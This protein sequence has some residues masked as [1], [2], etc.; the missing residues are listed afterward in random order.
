MRCFVPMGLDP[1]PLRP[2]ARCS[3]RANSRRGRDMDAVHAEHRRELHGRIQTH[4]VF[5][6]AG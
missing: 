2:G 6:D 4:D 5:S 3:G 1:A